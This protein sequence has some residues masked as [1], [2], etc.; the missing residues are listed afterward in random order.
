[1]PYLEA[2]ERVDGVGEE[3]ALS[4]NDELVDAVGG[5][6]TGADIEVGEEAGRVVSTVSLVSKAAAEEGRQKRRG[7]RALGSC[8]DAVDKSILAGDWIL[9]ISQPAWF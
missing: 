9:P 5:A 2:V 3:F 4:G 8:P 1:M 6:V 7:P